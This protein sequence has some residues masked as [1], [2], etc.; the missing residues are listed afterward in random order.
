MPTEPSEHRHHKIFPAAGCVQLAIEQADTQANM[1]ALAALLEAQLPAPDTLLVLPEMWASGFQYEETTRFAAETPG[2]L[3]EMERLAMRYGIYLAGSLTTAVPGL[4]LPTNSLYLVGPQGV[5]GRADKQFLFGAWHE[6]EHYRPG[7]ASRPIATPFGSVGAMVCYDLRF[8][9]IARDLAFAGSRLLVVS[10]EWPGSRLAHWRALVEARAIENQVFVVACNAC[11]QTGKMRMGGHALVVAPDGS[12]LAEA[13]EK[14][15]IITAALDSARLDEQ[16]HLFC[17]PAERPW[18]RND[19][20]KLCALAELLPRIAAIRA[21]TP[22]DGRARASRIAFTNGCFDLLHTGHVQ[23][24]EEARRTADCLV[25]GL[26]SDASVRLQGKGAGRPVNLQADRA[27]VLAGL[28]CVDFVVIFDEPTPLALIH[29]IQPDVLVKGADWPEDQIVGA[30]E[31]R[32]NGGEVRRIELAP[33]RSTTEMIEH[34]KRNV[35]K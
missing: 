27:R 1:A 19:A 21:Q 30:T 14:P 26:N 3:A 22:P 35:A 16:R 12:I 5:L 10:A 29:A 23:Y 20:D 18:R 7:R 31:V 25:V 33:G 6:D 11:G 13:G 24:L 9:E 15:S 32:A 2:I 17:S 28:G 34:I 4:A 8:P